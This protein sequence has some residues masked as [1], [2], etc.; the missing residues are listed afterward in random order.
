MLD[1]DGCTD[2]HTPKMRPRADFTAEHILSL[3]TRQLFGTSVLTCPPDLYCSTA[4]SGVQSI[5]RAHTDTS[6]NSSF[7]RKPTCKQSST[8]RANVNTLVRGYARYPAAPTCQTDSVKNSSI[9]RPTGFRRLS[10]TPLASLMA[11]ECLVQ[12]CQLSLV[13]ALRAVLQRVGSAS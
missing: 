11:F 8:R 3:Q 7:R 12:Q 2:E 13:V 5:V 1:V 6:S 10:T 4:G 9:P